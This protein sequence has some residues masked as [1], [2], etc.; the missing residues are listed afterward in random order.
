MVIETT[1]DC[2]YRFNLKIANFLMH[3][4]IGQDEIDCLSA[5][6]ILTLYETARRNETPNFI[7]KL[8]LH[9]TCYA[10]SREKLQI[11]GFIISTE[12]FP[13]VVFIRSSELK[14]S[15]NSNLLEFLQR[16]P[17]TCYHN[18]LFY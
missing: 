11:Y 3:P 5:P 1:Q 6:D 8:S 10:Q 13:S 12:C 9:R 17:P 14:T 4:E 7:D 2:F 15:L 16:C 18:D